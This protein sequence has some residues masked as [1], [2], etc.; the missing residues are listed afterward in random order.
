MFEFAVVLV[1]GVEQHRLGVEA[2]H[3]ARRGVHA[4]NR[5]ASYR[6]SCM[7]MLENSTSLSLRCSS[8]RMVWYA[9]AVLMVLMISFMMLSSFLELWEVFAL[10]TL[11]AHDTG[12]F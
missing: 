6:P 2:E 12:K 3:L 7:V 8:A 10:L 1:R 11:C 9:L 4:V 5:L